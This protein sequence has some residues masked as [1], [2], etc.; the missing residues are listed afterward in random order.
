MFVKKVLLFISFLAFSSCGKPPILNK[1]NIL[2]E[3]KIFSAQKTDI[4]MTSQWIIPPTSID[5]L[6]AIDISFSKEI[7]EYT[8]EA[9]LYMPEHHHGSSPIVIEKDRLDSKLYHLTE[10]SLF[11]TGHWTLTIR[12]MDDKQEIETWIIDIHLN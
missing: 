1:L 9:E 2:P 12:L 4:K 8:L 5:D 7:G 11:M 10:L 3:I 6:S